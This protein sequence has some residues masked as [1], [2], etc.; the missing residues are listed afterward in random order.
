[1]TEVNKNVSSQN[2]RTINLTR[3]LIDLPG[4]D[5]ISNIIPA[6]VLQNHV[7]VVVWV[8][9]RMLICPVMNINEMQIIKI[10]I[11]NVHALNIV[12]LDVFIII[13]LY[14]MLYIHWGSVCH[15]VPLS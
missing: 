11:Q 8:C 9:T 12:L 6:H 7:T 4:S 2:P 3:I 15:E 1:M 14:G 5:S 13:L 10:L